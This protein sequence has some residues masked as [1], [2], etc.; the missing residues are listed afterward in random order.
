MNQS[1]G[2]L[3]NGASFFPFWGGKISKIRGLDP[4]G[5]QNASEKIYA[6]LL[7]GITNLTNRIRY[8]GFYCWLLVVYERVKKGKFNEKDQRRFIRRAELAMALVMIDRNPKE[9]QIPGS[10][11]AIEILGNPETADTISISKYADE[12]TS[13]DSYWRYSTGAFGQYY[14]SSMYQ[15]GLIKSKVADGPSVFMA[16][17][18]A[19]FLNGI[20]LAESFDENLEN[21]AKEL[22]IESVLGGDLKKGDIPQIHSSFNLAE[23]PQKTR[24]WHYYHD[25]LFGPDLPTIPEGDSAHRS[26]TINEILKV[27]SDMSAAL[28]LDTFFDRGLGKTFDGFTTE[29]GWYQYRLNEFWQYACGTLFWSILGY[30]SSIKGG[31]YPKDDLIR[32][33]VE[34]ICR[35]AS[36]DGK[37]SVSS[38]IRELDLQHVQEAIFGIDQ[39]VKSSEVINAGSRA[40]ELLLMLFSIPEEYI[41]NY[42]EIIRLAGLNHNGSFLANMEDMLDA[43]SFG[44]AVTS[45]LVDFMASRILNRHRMVAINKMGTGSL[46]TLKFEE[47]RGYLFFDGNFEPSF[48]TPRIQTLFRILSDLGMLKSD[49]SGVYSV[50]QDQSNR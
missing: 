39:A 42:S 32:E 31:I 50:V 29:F 38:T 13:S 30:L 35:E 27:P 18:E 46:T 45:F 7:P 26:N 33:W 40:I 37:A 3:K 36:I 41:K 23:V 24:E 48:T 25:L 20:T 4:L 28:I 19:D 15:M 43:Q 11:K 8:Y 2:I 6:Y 47:E 17:M 44:M 5:Q 14:A 22:L 12:P 16:S 9:L 34:E 10:N 1:I 49:S 21:D